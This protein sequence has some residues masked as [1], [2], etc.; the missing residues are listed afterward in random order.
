M[1]VFDKISDAL[2]I[3]NTATAITPVTVV[4]NITND[5]GDMSMTTNIDA[6]YILARSNLHNLSTKLNDL[7]DES[8]FIAVASETPRSFEVAG[9][10]VDSAIALNLSL[11]KLN[12]ETK[13]IQNIGNNN[14]TNNNVTNNTMFVGSTHELLKCINKMK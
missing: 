5:I 6:D 1:A 8:M 10:L 4:P 2:N 9:K 7:I 11:M 13:K 12:A 14:T 3:D